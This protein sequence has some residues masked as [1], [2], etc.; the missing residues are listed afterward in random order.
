M[1]SEERV[2]LLLNERG[3][4]RLT[5]DELPANCTA[6]EWQGGCLCCTAGALLE[7]ALLELVEKLC[8][9]RIVVELAETA[10]IADVKAAFK[11]AGNGSFQIEHIIY[12]LN[13]ETFDCKWDLSGVFMARQL[14]DSL[15]I[16]LTNTEQADET[17][18]T[19]ISQTVIEYNPRYFIVDSE[20]EIDVFYRK[21]AQHKKIVFCSKA[22]ERQSAAQRLLEK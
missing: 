19:R 5:L 2:V 18:L 11:T 21:S 17:L 13:V 22:A 4:T 12:V 1:W 9:D 14:R 7:Q 3:R 8:P 10:R 15:A 20:R 6:E 16:W